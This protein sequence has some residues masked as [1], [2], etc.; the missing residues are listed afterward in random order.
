MTRA[1]R[2]KVARVLNSRE[3]ALNI[4]SADGVAVGMYFDVMDAEGE[5]I[6]DPDTGET[7]GSI[8]RAKVRVR[9]IHVQEKLSLAAT[10]RQRRVN[11]GGMLPGAS[12]S[13]FLMQP[14]WVSEYETLKSTEKTREP[15]SEE[16][17]YVEIGDPV[18][19]VIDNREEVARETEL[20]Q[21]LAT[22]SPESQKS[23]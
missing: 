17:S 15:L 14:E 22:A 9:T 11:T 8:Q 23:D 20:P 18:V 1:I 5:N 4:G 6:T 7:L 13:K 12:F 19:Q 16:E 21:N 10:Y 2:G 3:V